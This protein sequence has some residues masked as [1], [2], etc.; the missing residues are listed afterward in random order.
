VEEEKGAR[1]HGRATWQRGGLAAD[2]TQRRQRWVAVVPVQWVGP[3]GIVRFSFIQKYSN[4]FELIQSKDRP[5]LLEKIQIKYGFEGFKEG[6][7]FLQINIFRFKLY[8]E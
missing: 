8:F 2:S 6:S 4:E 3:Q 5:P 1:L 7:N